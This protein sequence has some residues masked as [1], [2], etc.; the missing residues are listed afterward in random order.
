MGKLTSAENEESAHDVF[1][2][3]FAWTVSDF[4]RHIIIPSDVNGYVTCQTV[5]NENP[6]SQHGFHRLGKPID[7]DKNNSIFDRNLLVR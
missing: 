6:E 4:F 3:Y 1:P 2:Q 5:R 7:N